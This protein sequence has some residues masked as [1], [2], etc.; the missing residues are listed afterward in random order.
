MPVC[1]VSAWDF[2]TM[3]KDM[4]RE[5]TLYVANLSPGV[6]QE[7]LRRLFACH[8]VVRASEVI[9]TSAPGD[10]TGAGFVEVDSQEHGEAAIASLNGTRYHGAVLMVGWADRRP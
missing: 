5:R 3:M 6:E 9:H 7:D 8:G 2:A 1:L 10:G 4:A